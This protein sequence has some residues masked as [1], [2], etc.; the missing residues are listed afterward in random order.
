MAP[1]I[2][3]FKK[4]PV[5]LLE[6]DAF[7]EQKSQ[8]NNFL[9]IEIKEVISGKINYQKLLKIIKEKNIKIILVNFHNFKNKD[10]LYKIMI[11]NILIWDIEKIKEFFTGKIDLKKIDKN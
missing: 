10:L 5:L 6:P 7:I 9:N 2:F 1:K 11:N 3:K 4:T 8:E